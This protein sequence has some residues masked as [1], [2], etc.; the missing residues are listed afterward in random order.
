MYELPY[1]IGLSNSS[2]ASRKFCFRKCTQADIEAI[3]ELQNKI[4]DIIPQKHIFAYTSEEE[5]RESI[6]QDLCI[7]AFCA[8][9]A[10]LFSIMVANRI[11]PRNLGK[12]LGFDDT[13]LMKTVT[14]DTTFVS[15]KFRGYGL[16]SLCCR[17][18]DA[19]ASEMGACRALATVSP[20]NEHS[21]K[22]VLAHG[23]EVMTER[24]MYGGLRR[25]IVKKELHCPE[26]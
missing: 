13:E 26:V 19:A 15:P 14:Y 25:Y 20:D 24:E 10:A 6:D 8:G 4:I 11:T 17:I 23:F 3:L 2:G 5:I 7:G 18:K 12:Y 22:N 21:L 1:C 9:E 16:Q